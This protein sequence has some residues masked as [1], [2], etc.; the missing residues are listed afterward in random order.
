[1]GG[2]GSILASNLS[3]QMRNDP[4]FIKL[5]ERASQISWKI[6][7]QNDGLI[8]LENVTKEILIRTLQISQNID[9]ALT[10][11]AA[12]LARVG[13]NDYLSYQS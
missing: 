6:S 12:E 13:V 11:T 7:I 3:H 1:M 8:I 4:R 2:N 5:Q 10:E 9:S